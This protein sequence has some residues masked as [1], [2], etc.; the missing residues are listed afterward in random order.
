MHHPD[1]SDATK[2][3]WLCKKCHLALHGAKL[4]V[5]QTKP[6]VVHPVLWAH[7]AY[8]GKV[9]RKSPLDVKRK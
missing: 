5:D 7:N 1:Y 2:I 8:G 3:V 4:T 6:Q 9:F